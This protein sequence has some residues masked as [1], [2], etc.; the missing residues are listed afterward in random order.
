MNNPNL[1][2]E[3]GRYPVGQISADGGDTFAVV[4]VSYYCSASATSPGD[5][6]NR[7]SGAASDEPDD[8]RS[9][10]YISDGMLDVNPK[11]PSRAG[12]ND[13]RC[14]NSG[15]QSRE[16]RNLSTAGGNLQSDNL[17]VFNASENIVTE[18]IE[19]SQ[20]QGFSSSNQ[21][22]PSEI[23]PSDIYNEYPDDSIPSEPGY[24]DAD[25]EKEIVLD[26]DDNQ[27]LYI[28]EFNEDADTNP[29]TFNGD[30]NDAVVLITVNEQG[31]I[32]PSG[33]FSLKISVKSIQIDS[34]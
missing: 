15:L 14:T 28:Y 23:I 26:L 13:D 31:A 16:L 4:G 1:S 33:S 7:P 25:S 32:P 5:A 30:F 17:L 19:Y 27:A 20:F 21:R 34:S 18:D 9:G 10:D 12:G 11:Y 6:L 2:H 24:S 22:K 8:D 29:N 3:N